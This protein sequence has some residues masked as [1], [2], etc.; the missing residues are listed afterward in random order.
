MVWLWCLALIEATKRCHISGEN[1]WLA[2]GSL[3]PVMALSFVDCSMLCIVV[4]FFPW[5]IEDAINSGSQKFTLANNSADRSGASSRS[6]GNND[7]GFEEYLE[8]M[9]P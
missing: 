4:F 5:E 1:I 2:L 7:E 9:F 3:E 6:S 8:G